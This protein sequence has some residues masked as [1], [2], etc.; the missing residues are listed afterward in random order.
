M[1]VGNLGVV[2]ADAL[3]AVV[4]GNMT[5]AGSCVVAPYKEHTY[6]AHLVCRS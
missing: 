6:R 1:I 5:V 3:L 4:S 2:V